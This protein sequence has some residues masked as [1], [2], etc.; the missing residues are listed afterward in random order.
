MRVSKRLKASDSVLGAGIDI[1]ARESHSLPLQQPP[2]KC[3]TRK[4]VG[5][6]QPGGPARRD[7]GCES[8]DW[9]DVRCA[10]CGGRRFILLTFKPT[11]N[12]DGG[13]DPSEMPKRPEL[14]CVDCG[15]R[16]VRSGN[17]PSAPLP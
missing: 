6:F 3:V 2:V 15:Q 8:Q 14:K 4:V 13:A 7:E 1:Q 16:Y 5:E 12:D 17:R 10:R 11:P 9:L